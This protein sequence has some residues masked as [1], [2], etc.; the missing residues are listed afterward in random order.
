MGW[1]FKALNSRADLRAILIISALSD[2]KKNSINRLTS[3]LE[4]KGMENQC[5]VCKLHYR[6]KKWADRCYIWCSAH[7]SCNLDITKNSLEAK[8]KK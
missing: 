8:R 2:A 6:N 3:M 5:S 7:D 1:K 4:D